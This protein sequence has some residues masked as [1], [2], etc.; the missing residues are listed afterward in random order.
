MLNIVI[1]RSEIE[2]HIIECWLQDQMTKDVAKQGWYADVEMN[3]NGIATV[4]W[5]V[6]W[7]YR[8][9][10]YLDTLTISGTVWLDTERNV[11]CW[12]CSVTENLP[13][14]SNDVGF[15]PILP[16]VERNSK[17]K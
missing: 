15:G 12:E 17:Q 10:P 6:A 14:Q 1:P 4:I 7:D 13:R 2:R 9:T 16:R 5:D 3:F 8:K 11:A